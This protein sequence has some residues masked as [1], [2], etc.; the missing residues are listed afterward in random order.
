MGRFEHID[1]GQACE[2][3]LDTASSP[4]AAEQFLRAVRSGMAPGGRL[5]AVLGV[6][7]TADPAQRREMGALAS[8]NCDELFLTAGSYR[9]NPPLHT[10]E[11]LVDGATAAGAARMT[12]IPDRE[13]AIAAALDGAGRG[14]VVAVMGRGNIVEA[15][16]DAKADDREV[17]YRL[18]RGRGDSGKGGLRPVG[19]DEAAILEL[20]VQLEQGGIGR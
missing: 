13:E 9:G 6:L 7:G 20:R 4:A 12:V 1:S 17:L 16:H 3:I 5:R 10:L 18:A 2:V 14:D 11:G 19:P 15:V 8:E